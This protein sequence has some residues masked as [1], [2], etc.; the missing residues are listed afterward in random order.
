MGRR[1]SP[2]VSLLQAGQPIHVVAERPGHA[3]IKTTLETYAHVLPDMLQDAVL[4]LHRLNA[5]SI[6]NFNN[7]VSAGEI[8]DTPVPPSVA[9]VRDR[10]AI[11]RYQG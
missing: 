3:N 7:R 10:S 5:S 11:P 2:R 4:A 6:Q 8:L 1:G 9:L